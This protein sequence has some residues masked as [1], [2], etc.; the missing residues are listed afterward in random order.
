[1]SPVFWSTVAMDWR[2]ELCRKTIRPSTP[3]AMALDD[4]WK[5][6]SRVE[7]GVGDGVGDGLELPGPTG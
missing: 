4:V 3:P 5:E 7:I 6:R 1:M 2:L